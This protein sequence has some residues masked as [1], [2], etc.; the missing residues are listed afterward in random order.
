M[1][2]RSPGIM[3]KL[4]GFENLVQ[5]A[6]ARGGVLKTLVS[7]F[8]R[9]RRNSYE[10]RV[11]PW[12]NEFPSPLSPEGARYEALLQSATCW[13]HEPQG[14]TLGSYEKLLWS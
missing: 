13:K 8:L 3:K 6:A 2:V 10:P 7:V 4:P 12:G 11:Q 5:K 14:Y 9:Q 1:S